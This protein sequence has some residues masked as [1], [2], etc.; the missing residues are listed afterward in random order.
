MQGLIGHTLEKQTH[1]HA[2]LQVADTMKGK[3]REEYNGEEE[4]G[5]GEDGVVLSHL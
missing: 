5:W 4:R 3:H 1:T 2:C